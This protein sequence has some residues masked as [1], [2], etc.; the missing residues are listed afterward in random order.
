MN[1][2]RTT[3]FV[4]TLAA[5][6]VGLYGMSST[7]A[8][9]PKVTQKEPNRGGQVDLKSIDPAVAIKYLVPA[10]GYRVNL[11][12][13]EKDFPLDNPVSITWDAK[14]RL[15][16]CTMP[17][18][19]HYLPGHPP[20]DKIIV[21]EDTDHDGKAD[22]YTVFADGLYL[23]TG[24]ELGDGGVYVA[25]EPN[26]VFLK[27]TDGDGKADFKRII[28]S[29]FGTE[30]SHHAISAFTWGP[31]GGLYFQEG[32][33][34][35]S[36]V[37]TPWGP[38]RLENAGIF[39]FEPRTFKLSV[40][41]SYPFANPWGHV[42]DGWGQNFVADASN[43]NNYF[44][45][46]FTGH[47]DYP[48]KHPPMKTFT[49]RVRPTAGCEFIRSRQFPDSVQG[50]FLVNNNIGFQGIKQH[51]VIEEGSGFTSKEVGS[52]LL[53]RDINFRPVDLQFGPDGALYICDWFNPLIG[54]MQ[55]SVRDPRRDHSHG[56]IWRLTYKNKPLLKPVKIAGEPLPVLLDLLKTYED[57]VRY[58]TRIEIRE[59]PR[60]QILPA[61][62]AW[63]AG[64]DPENP[65]HERY[66]L[67]ALWIY[68]G[69]NH[70]EP[71]LL[72]RVLRS[73]EPHARAAA[74]R[75]LRYWHDRIPNALELLKVQVND[76]QPR[77]R[78]EAL[79][80]LSDIPTSQSAE[81]ALD[82]LR[83]PTD[84]YLD[85]VLKETIKTLEKYW[86]PAIAAGKPFAVDN[87]KGIA[88]ILDSIPAHDL[89]KL[90]RSE[91]VNLALL[92]RTG[93]ERFYRLDALAA[94]AR[95]HHNNPLAEL[96]NTVEQLDRPGVRRHDPVLR[97]L[98]RILASQ[99]AKML[100][101]VRGRLERLAATARRPLTRQG[102]YV[103]LIAADGS[104]DRTWNIAT[105]SP[106]ALRDL[107]DAVPLIDNPATLQALY[108]RIQPLIHGLPASLN[109][110]FAL[111]KPVRGRYVR[112]SLP[113]KRGPLTLAEV[114]I[115]SGGRNIAPTGKARQKSTAFGGVASRAIDGNT[116]GNF[117][118]GGQSH[119]KEK[120][121]N[122]WWE[123][124]LRRDYPIDSI[125]IW[126]R[127]EANGKYADRLNGFTLQ[128]LDARRKPVFTK[129]NN[130]APA[131]SVTIRMGGSSV[132][133]IR[134]A[135]M[136]AITFAPGHDV[137][138]FRALAG[139]IRHGDQRADA[140]RAIEHIP[141][142]TWPK[143]EAA[144][145]IESIFSFVR[146][147]PP[148]QR[149]RTDVIDSLQ[150]SNDLADLLPTD[151]AA[152]IRKIIREIGVTTIVVHTVPHEMLFDR[153]EMAVQ[154]GK[155]VQIIFK[156]I[157]I[158]PH[159][160]V[161]GRPGS[162]VELGE[163]S[164]RTGTAPDA[165]ARGFVPRSPQVMFATKL[166]QTG[167][168]ER[169]TFLAPTQ[170]AD[171][172][173]LCTFPGHWRRMN[174]VLHVVPDLDQYLEK[175]PLATVVST[176]KARPVVR[177]WKFNDLVG[178][179]DQLNHGRSFQHGR[180]L[181]KE[182]S[183]VVCHSM[184]KV[185]GIAGPDLAK[186]DKKLKTA[187][188]LREVLEPSKVILKNYE[189]Y[190]IV[191]DEGKQITGRIIS[192]DENSITVLANP[193]GQKNPK[194]V[195]IEREAIEF[196]KKTTVS[197]MPQKLLN[198]FTKEEI[199]DLLAYIIARG[200]PNAPQFRR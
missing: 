150:L 129:A 111:Q 4:V 117:A 133:V 66:L 78:L 59:R 173:Y 33:F 91:P 97:D 39:R 65:N 73:P 62:K 185:G 3:P 143:T 109:E 35:H 191:T 124:D 41:V 131:V 120:P 50:D 193:L 8:A 43:G 55:Y 76:K 83:H 30:D 175:H 103:A 36:Q 44:G 140:V 172:P 95:D 81:V 158:M 48:R 9:P 182:A 119:T 86:K 72:H 42:F 37:E 116:S 7:E 192:K 113:N 188:I 85:Y 12:A 46:A 138:T 17:S 171:Y 54:H 149:V 108:P 190:V 49:S 100:A 152:A 22:K 45:T 198:T 20:D 196:Q 180:K 115:S 179:L 169:L 160:L 189:S 194:P 162:L 24:F 118:D 40:F 27:D 64:L 87:P 178:S 92:T 90:A 122:P 79:L 6:F 32:T 94:L 106:A 93:V 142:N 165:Y 29:S 52:L 89:P 16:V 159:N 148:K 153:K 63:I 5:L 183:C 77:V 134:A 137:D 34:L 105:R 132:G 53:S 139:F 127:S 99:P 112:I 47:V 168:V 70:V 98:S 10:E 130:P 114:Q 1:S 31:G 60:R 146:T 80:A 147:V 11:F 82:A 199:L 161:V 25:Q 184:S 125:T 186:W 136:Y 121:R 200:D 67:E 26:L 107:L 151:R 167:D 181:F 174:G 123:V 28:L 18:Y 176:G 145:L 170:A 68:Q 84:Y 102:A 177:D 23:P 13:S 126:N 101:G 69:I 164:E 163:L 2:T 61:L 187:D 14:G 56:R 155:P 135:A 57:R 51:H 110:S 128:I 166:L 58:R 141:H 104:I 157:D 154:V 96:L 74:T 156:N 71:K 38:V 197:L 144:S 15:W 88:Y 75:V 21:L 19:P 195:R